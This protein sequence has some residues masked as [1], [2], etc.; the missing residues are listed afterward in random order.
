MTHWLLKEGSGPYGR[1]LRRNRKRLG[2]RKRKVVLLIRNLHP[3][4]SG[5]LKATETEGGSEDGSEFGL[6]SQA[7][8][9]DPMTSH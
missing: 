4:E 9:A 5:L 7:V 3:P 1:R 6:S 2:R 8:V